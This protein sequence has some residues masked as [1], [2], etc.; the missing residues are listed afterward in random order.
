[1]PKTLEARGRTVVSG[2]PSNLF[3][4]PPEQFKLW[5]ETRVWLD[6]PQSYL[7]ELGAVGRTPDGQL[8]LDILCLH[9]HPQ[10]A[11]T[12][13][14]S[15]DGSVDFA[16]PA[17]MR[18]TDL[19]LLQEVWELEDMKWAE[20]SLMGV[21]A[22]QKA[23]WKFPR[24][25]AAPTSTQTWFL[26]YEEAARNKPQLNLRAG[27]STYF[28]KTDKN[29][30]LVTLMGPGLSTLKKLLNV[31]KVDAPGVPFRSEDTKA[32]IAACLDI[33]ADYFARKLLRPSGNH[34]AYVPHAAL[35]NMNMA[36]MSELSL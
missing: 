22:Y 4:M 17:V 20:S 18:L 2:R 16:F 27:W 5:E 6:D 24:S 23:D 35:I 13:L 30:Q 34:L 21:P 32:A 14:R 33:G 15:R 25:V 7:N 11:Y 10:Y 3:S 12:R 29:R 28:S 8:L 1:M 9:G 26:T 19:P 31:V 36:A